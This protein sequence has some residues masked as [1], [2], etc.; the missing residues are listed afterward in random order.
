MQLN[1]ITLFPQMVIDAL[2]YGV[3]GRAIKQGVVTL[4]LFN[5]RDYA[6]NKHNSVDDKPF[7]GGSGMVMMYDSLF[8]TWQDVRQ[9]GPSGPLLFMS[10]QGQTLTQ[11]MCNDWSVIPAITLLC[12]RYE[13]IDQRV[14]E[15]HVDEE[16]SLGDYV[17]SGGE[18]AASIV[19]DAVA[20]Q[21]SGV[22]GA[23][24]SAKT[25][26]FMSPLLAPP[27]YT[28]SELLGQSGVPA[29]LL[30]GNHKAIAEW[31]SFQA[32]EVTKQ[33]RPDLL[34]GTSGD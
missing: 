16:V 13:G 12:G 19:I 32:I 6:E 15:G 9:S 7:G 2:S 31:K 3:I 33:K 27:Q 28:R 8:R 5:P 29:V 4:S 34:A 11:K 10:P 21:I 30:S 26:S 22:L 14:I 1:V 17:I 18:L 20:R 25:D 24:D 23:E